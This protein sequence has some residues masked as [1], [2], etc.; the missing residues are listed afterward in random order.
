MRVSIFVK[1]A[2]AAGLIGGCAATAAA[3]QDAHNFHG[4]KTLGMIAGYCG[5]NTSALAGL[6][7]SYRFNRWLRLAPQAEY[8]VRHKDRDALLL[9]VNVQFPFL[10]SLDRMAVY[11]QVGLNYSSW[12]YHF[13]G[14]S[15]EYDAAINRISR[16]GLN[17]GAGYELDLTPSLRMGV[18]AEYLIVKKF[19]SFNAAVKIAY[20]F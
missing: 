8:V 3:R 12:N 13:D 1:G 6:E 18:I 10:M 7:F 9:N 5:S 20:R 14:G 4:E 2:L 16:F 19:N 17:V 11:P 15:Q